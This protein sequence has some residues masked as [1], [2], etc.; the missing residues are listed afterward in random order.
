MK[1]DSET[2]ARALGNS[3]AVADKHYI[4]PQTALPDVRKR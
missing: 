3:K 2:R 1:A 4:K